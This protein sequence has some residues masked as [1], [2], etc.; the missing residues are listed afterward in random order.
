VVWLRSILLRDMIYDVSQSD[1]YPAFWD[2]MLVSSS[3]VE[4]LNGKLIVC[5]TFYP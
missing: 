4:K 2:S 3:V 1:W 5:G